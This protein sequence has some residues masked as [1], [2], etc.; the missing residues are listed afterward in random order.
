MYYYSLFTA[1]H[2]SLGGTL[3]LLGFLWRDP[4]L[5]SHGMVVELAY[6]VRNKTVNCY[7]LMAFV[8]AITTATVTHNKS[9]RILHT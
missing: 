7:A 9:V 5:T 8:I 2:H 6:E 1:V 4:A 3:L